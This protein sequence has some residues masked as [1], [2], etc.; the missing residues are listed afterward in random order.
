MDEGTFP[1]ILLDQV[2]ADLRLNLRIDIPVERRHP[3]AMDADIPLDYLCDLHL[4]GSP[5]GRFLLGA[6][7]ALNNNEKTA[8]KRSSCS[9]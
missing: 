1:V 3:L 8:E 9:Q 5:R 4:R 7:S 6:S 2:P